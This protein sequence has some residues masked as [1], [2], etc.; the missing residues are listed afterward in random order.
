MLRGGEEPTLTSGKALLQHMVFERKES[1]LIEIDL[2][3][4]I[5]ES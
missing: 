4:N 5:Y 3:K 2:E 1:K